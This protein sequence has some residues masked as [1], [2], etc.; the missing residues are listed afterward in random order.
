MYT[1]TRLQVASICAA[2]CLPLL[3]VA[4]NAWAEPPGGDETSSP[5]TTESAPPEP[6]LPRPSTPQQPRPADG[7]GPPRLH[8]TYNNTSTFNTATVSAINMISS[9]CGGCNATVTVNGLTAQAIWTGAGWTVT[10]PAQ[11]GPIV[12]TYVPTSVV[13]GYVQTAT[14][15]TIGICGASHPVQST[16]VRVG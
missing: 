4:A 1:A 13:N 5:Q 15:T 7:A 6:Q 2:A 3:T 10:T 11:C 16:L 14:G 12:A 8:G 9:P